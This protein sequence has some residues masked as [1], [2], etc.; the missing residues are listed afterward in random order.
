MPAKANVNIDL[1]ITPYI[2]VKELLHT[3]SMEHNVTMINYKTHERAAWVAQRFG[4]AFGPGPDPGDPGSSPM[5][6]FLHGACVSLFLC[7]C[8]SLSVF[9]I[10]K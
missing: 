9:L 4:A 6:G 1:R 3:G 2:Q 7:L 5:S 10:N 8:F